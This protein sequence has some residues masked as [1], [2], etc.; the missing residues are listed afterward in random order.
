MVA[1]EEGRRCNHNFVGTEQVLLGIIGE[2]TSLAAKA[3]KA[4][5]LNLRDLRIEVEK[6]IGRGA[7]PISVEMPFTP[8]MA[9][10][11]T[12]TWAEAR[13]LKSNE[14]RAEHLLLAILREGEGVAAMVLERSNVTLPDL[15]ATLLAMIELAMIEK[16]KEEN[17]LE[18]YGL[19]FGNGL[20]FRL[21]RVKDSEG[22]LLCRLTV[23]YH[24]YGTV[25]IS[26]D[27]SLESL[28]M[29]AHWIQHFCHILE[30]TEKEGTAK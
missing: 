12:D 19:D 25:A 22:R 10:V 4:R 8:R 24:N 1:Q 20:R 7:G 11:L 16:R 6:I 29:L 3:M 28:L 23:T 17:S 2:G 13:E 27:F 30:R 5:G 15:R 14:I 21:E 9:R 18:C 26:W